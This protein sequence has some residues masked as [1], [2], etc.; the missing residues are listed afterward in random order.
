MYEISLYGR[1]RDFNHQDKIILKTDRSVSTKTLK[2]LICAHLQDNNP[3]KCNE[4]EEIIRLSA[5]TDNEKILVADE[6]VL[7]GQI[8]VLPPVSGG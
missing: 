6:I 3:D 4:F 8:S 2:T 5:L 7:Q 1:L